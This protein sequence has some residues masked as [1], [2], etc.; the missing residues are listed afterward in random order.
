[1]FVNSKMYLYPLFL[2]SALTL[3]LAW[4]LNGMIKLFLPVDGIYYSESDSFIPRHAYRLNEA[5]SRTETLSKEQ[6]S[7]DSSS[8]SASLLSGWVLKAIYRSSGNGFIVVEV[9][10]QSHYLSVGETLNGYKLVTIFVDHALFSKGGQGYQLT[11]NLPEERAYGGKK[12][13]RFDA[14]KLQAGIIQ[15][16]LIDYHMAH[17]QEVWRNIQIG[18]FSDGDKIGFSVKFVQPGSV[19][20]HGGLKAGDVLMEINGVKLDSMQNVKKLY[21]NI[22]HIDEVFLKINRKG[23]IKELKLEVQ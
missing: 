13:M 23:K 11:L 15:R 6:N 12:G 1:M 3:L 5:F 9:G 21:A 19:F 18:R 17:P 14:A 4:S 7:I 8:K 16:R 10:A 20:E 2:G 22:E